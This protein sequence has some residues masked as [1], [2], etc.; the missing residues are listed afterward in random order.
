[1][2]NTI[3]RAKFGIDLEV[4]K[5]GLQELKSSLLE[6]N[7]LTATG[8]MKANSNLEFK[9]AVTQLTQVKETANTVQNALDKAFN[10]KLGTINLTEFNSSL[11]ASGLNLKQIYN[12][13]SSIGSVGQNA[14]RNLTTELLTTNLQLKE[15]H[16]L[17]DKMAQTMGNT[18]K[19]GIASGAMNR[20]ANSVSDAFNYVEKLDKSLN[21]I[22]IVTDKSA[23][24]M[25]R[26]AIQ[27]N[28]AAQTL[29]AS[30]RDYTEASL[31]YYQQGLGDEETNIRTQATLKA[32]NVTGQTA[33]EV[34]EQLTAV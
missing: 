10:Q 5:N 2:A 21:D 19:W 29:G 17:I 31:I 26:F 25:E 32:A 23:E 16:T 4:N 22:R 27:S 12:Q 28:K 24:D 13:F 1:M 6:I 18:I 34:S 33:A 8:L 3:G 20:F 30:T 7:N 9:D 11:S 15:S 14:F